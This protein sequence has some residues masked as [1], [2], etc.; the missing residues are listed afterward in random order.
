MCTSTDIERHPPVLPFSMRVPQDT[1]LG[2]NEDQNWKRKRP[3]SVEIVEISSVDS[4]SKT[5]T[6]CNKELNAIGHP[7]ASPHDKPQVSDESIGGP[8][9]KVK[10]S[11]KASSLPRDKIV[12]RQTLN[13]ITRVPS[14]TNATVSIF[15]RKERCL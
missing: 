6:T 7:M 9:S 1:S 8:T 11:S 10:S 15:G 5:H 2:T 12:I 3:N 4:P 13:E 14:M